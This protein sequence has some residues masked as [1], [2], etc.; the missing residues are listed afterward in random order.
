MSRDLTPAVV[1]EDLRALADSVPFDQPTREVLE[2]AAELLDPEG[3]AVDAVNAARATYRA[4]L[5]SGD[6]QVTD[7]VP[8]NAD[9]SVTV[10]V[11]PGPL[12]VLRIG[13]SCSPDGP[14]E[15]SEP[16][17]VFTG[18]T[19]SLPPVIRVYPA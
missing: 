3:D 2:R 5:F 19:F 13:V 6:K 11:P 8:F 9:G 4:A 14:V 12:Q 17:S 16:R 18:D 15:Y 10:P 7:W 1:A